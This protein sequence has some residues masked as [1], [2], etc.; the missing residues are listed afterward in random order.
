MV[1]SRDHK[2]ALSIGADRLILSGGKDRSAVPADGRAVPNTF[3]FPDLRLRFN[4]RMLLVVV[5]VVALVLAMFVTNARTRVDWANPGLDDV[6]TAAALTLVQAVFLYYC[7]LATV[8]AR[9]LINPAKRQYRVRRLLV[10][11]PVVVI[12]AV[13]TILQILDDI[14]H[15][16]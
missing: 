15:G 10:Y 8:V 5:A 16:R 11:G 14:G 6:S 2:W 7:V 4:L 1:H 3:E 9:G 13:L 12:A